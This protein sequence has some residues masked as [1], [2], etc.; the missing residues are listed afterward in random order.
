LLEGILMGNMGVCVIGCCAALFHT[1]THVVALGQM[2]GTHAHMRT[3]ISAVG[4]ENDMDGHIIT[5][6]KGVKKDASYT[7]DM[8]LS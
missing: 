2:R 5:G 4:S 8:L 1:H 7:P 6:Q 3:H